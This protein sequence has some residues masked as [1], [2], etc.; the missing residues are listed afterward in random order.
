[1]ASTQLDPASGL[2]RIRFRFGGKGYFRSLGTRNES[3]AEALR[4][5]A[6]SVITA[7]G[8]GFLTIPPGADPADF[9]LAGGKSI[10][11][12]GVIDRPKSIT[13]PSLFSAYKTELT[14]G[15]KEP[16]SIGTEEVH[17][18][19]LLAHFRKAEIAGLDHR[20]VQAYVN[21][22][23]AAGVVAVTIKKELTTLRMIW[24]WGLHNRHIAAPLPWAMRR[25]TFPK[26]AAREPF[27][28]WG[29]IERKIAAGRKSKDWTSEREETLWECL[30]LDEAQ[31]QDC[32][33][34][35]C[36]HARHRFL[37][38]MFCFVAYTGARRSEILR[39]ERED[40]DLT[41]GTVA[42]RQKKSDTSKTF[43]LRHVPIHPD[44]AT[45][46]N[47]WFRVHPGGPWAICTENTLPIGIRMATKYFRGAVKGSKWEVLH[48]FHTF[49]HSLAS[50][51]ASRGVDQRLIDDLLGH[52][53][54]E[55]TRRYRH[56]FPKSKEVAVHS[57]FR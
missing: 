54:E 26:E 19:H 49:R 44:L 2:Y 34:H 23:S 16:N 24:N 7:I 46:M 6:E 53:T 12:I 1:M 56:L 43:T 38:P 9:I 4:G 55:M 50:V 35:I 14:E 40:W 33:A 31:I 52:S 42:I 32:L 41:N 27:Q 37:H 20:A 3:D 22:R 47:G 18:R 51:M 13:L 25:L 5:R 8:Q 39:S 29:Q 45:V 10:Q 15:S 11:P 57:L 48:G 36:E 30:Y 17:R 21:A 28:T